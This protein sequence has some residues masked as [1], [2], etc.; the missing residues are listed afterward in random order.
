[1]SLTAALAEAATSSCSTAKR[2]PP[3]CDGIPVS[4]PQADK[5][6]TEKRIGISSRARIDFLL[7]EKQI[8]SK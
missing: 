3:P 7:Y 1:M 4:V 8:V 6:K 2:L 5:I